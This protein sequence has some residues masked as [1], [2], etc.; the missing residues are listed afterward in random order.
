MDFNA[1]APKRIFIG[2]VLGAVLLFSGLIYYVWHVGM[3]QDTEL[4][5]TIFTA[6]IVA[7]LILMGFIGLVFGGMIITI[8][9]SES[10]SVPL[11][12][13]L[14]RFTISYFFPLALQ[15]G[16]ILRIQ[17]KHIM[18]SFIQVNNQMVL[19]KK[20]KVPAERILLLLPH[21][22]QNADCKHKITRDINNCVMC[23]R[24]PVN[25][26][27]EIRDKHHVHLRVVTGGT[28][29]RQ[30]VKSVRPKAIVAVACERDLVSGIIDSLPLPV[31]GVLNVR[32]NG[33]CFNTQVIFEE[34]EIA[35]E[36]LKQDVIWSEQDESEQKHKQKE[37]A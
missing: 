18:Q 34:I 15:I 33:P 13:N 16:K 29:A 31:L 24:C 7:S 35:I 27:M 19:A 3:N 6:I 17:K 8:V 22:V 11:V 9:R 12:Q 37:H 30:I 20:I 21:C 28:L 5:R 25:Q 32:P 4:Y 23:G 14:M 36:Q 10:F 26:L 1:Y 2:L